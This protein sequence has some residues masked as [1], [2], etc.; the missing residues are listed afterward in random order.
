MWPPGTTLPISASSDLVLRRIDQL[1]A[2][3]L[4]A[5]GLTV[6]LQPVASSEAYAR[7]VQRAINFTPI[8]WTQRSDPNG[9]QYILLH[10]NGFANTTGYANPETDAMLDQARQS[11]DP[12]E[13]KALYARLV[14]GQTLALREMPFVEAAWA[15]GNTQANVVRRHIWPNLARVVAAQF[16][17][18]VSAAIFTSA[19]LSFLG[20]GL[21]PPTPDWGGMVQAG[22]EYLAL[23]PLLCLGPGAAVTLTIFA[24]YVLGRT[25]D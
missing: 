17:V 16:A 21:P 5:V 9:L 1:V 2:E 25:V 12:S 6:P 10:S 23:N 20:F 4:A 8:S 24:F 18:S 3:Q 22:F 19:S 13:R 14:R 11:P 15:T 7:V